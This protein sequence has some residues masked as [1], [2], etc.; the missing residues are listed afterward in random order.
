MTLKANIQG[1]LTAT[2]MEELKPGQWLTLHPA[3]LHGDVDGLLD[4]AHVKTR[5]IGILQP[6][7][8]SVLREDTCS[9]VLNANCCFHYSL[10]QDFGSGSWIRIFGDSG[11]GSAFEMRI[12]IH[13][14]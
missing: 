8:V 7:V 14:L 3:E 2:V 10:G 6:H 11:S 5:E 4:S 12:R 9:S 1:E 13:A